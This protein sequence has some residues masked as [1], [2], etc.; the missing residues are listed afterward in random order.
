MSEAQRIIEAGKAAGDEA[1]TAYDALEGVSVEFMLGRW[2]ASGI[3]T[4]HPLDG[5]LEAYGWW[6]KEFTSRTEMRPLLF[7][8]RGGRSAGS[9]PS[10]GSGLVALD[11][12][13][14]PIHV[15]MSV[16]FRRTPAAALAFR[17]VSRFIHTSESRAVLGVVEHRGVSSAAM[18]YQDQP[19][20][21][22]FRRVD[23][24][25]VLAVM[26][27]RGDARRYFFALHRV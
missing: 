17:V 25:T 9:G 2:R 27:L 13:F 20:T 3:R 12:R 18:S 8:V 15:A 11:P 23:D 6:G 26:E 14:L 19:I 7:R 4:G 16:P 1:L 24:Q 5:V 21:D 22:Y 10:S